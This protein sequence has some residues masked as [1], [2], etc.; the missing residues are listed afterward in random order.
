MINVGIDELIRIEEAAAACRTHFSTVF[1]WIMKG[2]RRSDGQFVRLEAIRIGGKWVT[3]QKA[4]QAFAEATTPKRDGAP[5]P[6]TR[7]ETKRRQ[8]SE[9]AA[10]ELAAMGV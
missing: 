7:T 10:R 6:T 1:R 2:V 4:L 3:T 5:M 8:A 9:R